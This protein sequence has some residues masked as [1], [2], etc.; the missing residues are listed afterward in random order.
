[1]REEA[2]AVIIGA[3][4]AGLA[5]A[6]ELAKQG[7]RPIVL[8]K[9]YVG[10]GASSRNVGRIRA[11]QADEEL[12][13]LALGSQKIWE[14]I[15]DELN[16]NVLYYKCGY[17]YLLYTEAELRKMRERIGMWNRLGLKAKLLGR[18]EVN[19]IVPT[20]NTEDVIAAV[21]NE[22]DAIVHHDPVIW[23]FTRALEA[24]GVDI[25]TG[26]AVTD[27]KFQN[28]SIVGVATT[29]GAIATRV[30]VNAAGAHSREI[31][32]LI[33][34]E[35]PNR[36]FRREVFVTEP[37]KPFLYTALRFDSPLVGWFNQTLRGE[38]VGGV[39]DPAEPS[40]YSMKS[41]FEF[42]ARAATVLLKKMPCLGRL[43]IMR[44]WGGLYDVT[45]DE[46][47]ILGSIDSIDGYY[48]ECGWSG[49]GFCLAPIAAR[50]LTECIVNGREPD[51]L[52]PF[53]YDRFADILQKPLERFSS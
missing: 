14:T 47:P 31:A 11:M 52:R 48:Q 12:T 16:F 22:G 27:I 28:D 19:E 29:Q 8:E 45:P 25:I 4:I 9:N 32:R 35:L 42:L 1:M 50:L 24:K 51:L 13:R 49:R 15:P 40:S 5:T 33:G 38:V 43:N 23:G 20:L 17:L 26:T 6:L 36:P 37:A 53:K 18:V 7:W 30:V 46:K 10:Y 34:I 44:Q 3:G 2:D 39:I 21:F 41:S